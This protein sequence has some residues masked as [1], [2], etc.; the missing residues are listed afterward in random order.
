[1]KTPA[2]FG[3]ERQLSL[4]V[5]PTAWTLTCGDANFMEIFPP[6]DLPVFVHKVYSRGRN[7]IQ[8]YYICPLLFALGVIPLAL[9]ITLIILEST[10]A[11]IVMRLDLGSQLHSMESIFAILF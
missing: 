4:S 2:A 3:F 7:S 10:R 5:H 6:E 11:S 1:M 9:E 8:L